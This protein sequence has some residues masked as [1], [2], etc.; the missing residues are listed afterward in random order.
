ML[1]KYSNIYS[2]EIIMSKKLCF[3]VAMVTFMPITVI[4]SVN[5]PKS[6]PISLSSFSKEQI[7]EI[8]EYLS[9]YTEKPYVMEADNDI[10]V[11]IPSIFPSATSCLLLRI[12]IE[13][14]MFLRFVRERLDFFEISNGIKIPF[15]R[16]SKRLDEQI[17]QLSALCVEIENT[18]MNLERFSLSFNDDEVIEGYCLQ[19]LALSSFFGV[20]INKLSVNYNDDEISK[21]N[22]FSL[23]TAFCS[24]VM[25]LA[26]NVGRDR[27][28]DFELC[29]SGGLVTVNTSFKLLEEMKITTETFL[30]DYLATNRKM[31]FEYYN[32]G[33]SF[34]TAF[35]PTFF[36]WSYLGI[37]QNMGDSTLFE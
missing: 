11:V 10:Y 9:R 20:P 29:F 15:A 31:F 2:S 26:K 24:V 3:S 37:K 27:T 22:S 35:Q 1:N 14:R 16:M 25:M 13:P 18:F 34:V 19:L 30:W 7:E 28:I 5:S 6:K 8:E 32:E 12:E 23:F 21:Q 33:D 17:E 4:T 36:D